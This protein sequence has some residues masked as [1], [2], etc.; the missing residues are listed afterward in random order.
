[1]DFADDTALT[2]E[3]E[4]QLQTET[5]Q[6]E[7][8]ARNIGLTVNSKKTKVMPISRDQQDINTIL[9]NQDILDNVK[10][11]VYLGNTVT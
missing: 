6:V 11:F 2:D 4:Q 7:D 3:P 5:S 9:P 1:M 10:K 8:N